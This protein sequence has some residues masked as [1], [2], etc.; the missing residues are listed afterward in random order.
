VQKGT[1]DCRDLLPP[2][3]HGKLASRPISPDDLLRLREIGPHWRPNQDVFVG[4]SP[5]GKSLAFVMTRADPAANAECR[6]VVTIGMAPGSRPMV[7][8]QGGEPVYELVASR[9]LATDYGYPALNQP[10]WSPD[11]RWIAYLRRDGGVTRLWKASTAGG[12]AK[13]V[14]Q[15]PV[16]IATFAWSRD[17]SALIYG[18]RESVTA[19]YAAIAREGLSGYL[20]DARTRPYDHTA[21]DISL[22]LPYTYHI[23]ELATGKVRPASA[24]EQALAEPPPPSTSLSYYFRDGGFS[25]GWRAWTE[26]DDRT[27]FMSPVR[28]W[29]ADGSGHR[30]VCP[31]PV[32]TGTIDD[33]LTGLWWEGDGHTV[34]FTRRIG[35]ETTLFSWDVRA[36]RARRVFATED[37]L[38]GCQ[39][40][41]PALVCAREGS[42][43]P[44]QIVAIDL[45]RGSERVIFDPNPEF[46]EVRLGSV[47]RLH[48]KNAYGIASFGDLVLPPGFRPETADPAHRLPLIV[49]QYQTRGF[50]RGGTGDEYPIQLF[51]ARGYAVLSVQN[52]PPYYTREPDGPWH[53]SEEAEVE[54]MRN[55]NLRK[56]NLSSLVTGLEMVMARG[57]V[58]PKR[59]GLTGLSDGSTTVQ[60]ALANTNLFAAASMSSAGTDSQSMIY[61]GPALI[62]E[63]RGEG[64]PPAGS[65]NTAFWKASSLAFKTDGP[66]VPLLMQLADREMLLGLEVYTTLRERHWPVELYSFPDEHHLKEQPAHRAAIYRRNLA[67]FDFWLKGLVSPDVALAPELARWTS[68]KKEAAAADASPDNAKQPLVAP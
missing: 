55:F 52:P 22:P 47:E 45:A 14:A 26:Q 16:D 11:G 23:I 30:I 62:E 4:V 2:D 40:D 35:S 38:A 53:T 33:T 46:A 68:L 54:N 59:I 41:G 21:P 58:D 36:R 3:W 42:M 60:F 27:R 28:L 6:A 56:S 67:W 61:G 64:Y 10:R 48:W 44:R 32:C 13:P 51:A 25:A 5:D 39:L 7:V 37:L 31:D 29:V 63:R 24:D 43:Q 57:Y 65:D 66:R 12:N 20:Y 8:D 34:L 1:P 49:V 9:G 50:L 17:S 19:A 15:A 18:A